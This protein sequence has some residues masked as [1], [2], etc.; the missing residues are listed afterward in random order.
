[1]GASSFGISSLACSLLLSSS[2]GTILAAPLLPTTSCGRRGKGTTPH[3]PQMKYTNS[4]RLVWTPHTYIYMQGIFPSAFWATITM[5]TSYVADPQGERWE[6]WAGAAQCTCYHRTRFQGRG[7]KEGPCLADK[8]KGRERGER[9]NRN[10]Y[11]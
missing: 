5:G 11:S 4:F 3:H 8:E 2:R 1:M 9:L 10:R 6:E 7:W